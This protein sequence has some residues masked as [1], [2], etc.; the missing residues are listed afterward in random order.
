MGGK[1]DCYL[2]I[3]SLYSYLAFLDLRKN[4]ELLAAHNVEVEFHPVLLGA[5]NAG[6]GN[7]P[8]WTLPAKAAYGFF[9][10]NRSIARHPG[11]TVQ[12][13]SDLMSRAKTVLPLRCLHHIKTTLP[14]TT[15]FLPTLQHLL[16]LFWAPP[17]ADLT[18][19]DGVAQALRSVPAPGGA[20]TARRLLFSDDEVQAILA[21]AG[22]DAMKSALKAAT[23]AALDKGAFGAPWL[24]VVDGAGKE[25]PFFGSDRFHF[26]YEFLGLPYQAVRLLPPGGGEAKL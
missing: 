12:F 15:H 14:T 3:A 2:D 13:P 5:I 26:V 17:N 20:G 18:T 11:L 25:E 1:I 22:S 16:H 9:D 23:Q 10:A 21:A 7:R 8:P 6:S 19:V 24:W 4:S